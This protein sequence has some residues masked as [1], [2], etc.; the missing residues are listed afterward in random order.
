M[1]IDQKCPVAPYE[2][3]DGN[4]VDWDGC[5]DGMI[6]EFQVNTYTNK[7]QEDPAVATLADG[8]Y[9]IVWESENQDGSSKGIFAQPYHADGSPNGLELQVN[10]QAKSIPL[11]FML[12]TRSAP[13]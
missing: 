11:A 6:S 13:F 4:T 1:C 8:G 3:D 2:C 10:S 7:K 12:A 5:T 9:V